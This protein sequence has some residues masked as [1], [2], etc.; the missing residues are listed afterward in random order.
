MA[1]Y[2][3]SGLLDAKLTGKDWILKN[4]SDVVVVDDLIYSKAS[5]RP[6]K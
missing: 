3:K 1:R 5:N 4:Q 6:T 2:M